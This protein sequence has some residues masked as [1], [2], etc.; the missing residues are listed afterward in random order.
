MKNKLLILFFI[1]L[2]GCSTQ[3]KFYVQKGVMKSNGKFELL[4]DKK[5]FKVETGD[6]IFIVT[7]NK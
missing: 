4:E 6:T 3:K 1:F 7:K 5:E 2:I